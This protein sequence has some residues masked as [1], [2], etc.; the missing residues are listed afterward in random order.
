MAGAAAILFFSVFALYFRRFLL[1][2][3]RVGADTALR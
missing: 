3:D 2:E 1:E